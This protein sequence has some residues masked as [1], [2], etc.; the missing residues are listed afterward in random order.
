MH[1]F[2]YVIVGG[3]SAGCVL[4]A[5]LS[6]D[7]D[8][9]V[10]LLEAGGAGRSWLVR[11][12]FGMVLTVPTPFINWGFKTVP[13][14][15]LN[16]R[17]LYQ[18]RGRVLGGSSTLNA[19]IYTRGHP[20]D[21]DAWAAAG[22][23]SWSWAEVLPYF[24]RAENNSR[25][26]DAYHGGEGP[27]PVSDSFSGN[28]MHG[29]FLDAARQAGFV[30]MPDFN[31]VQQEGV[32]VYQVTQRQGER[33]S[34]ARAYLEPN[35]SRSNLTVLT[36]ARAQRVLFD[37]RRA[38]GVQYRCGGRLGNVSARREIILSAGTF[39]SPQLL[40]LSGIGHGEDL[41]NLGIDAL[42]HLPCVGA[43]LQDHLDYTLIHRAHSL[44]LIGASPRG[45]LRFMREFGRY[46]RERRGM[47]CTNVAEAGGFLKTDAA[48]PRPDVQLHFCVAIVH[49]HGRSVQHLWHGY[50]LHVCVLRP[51]SRGQVSLA[52][53]DPATAPLIDPAYLSDGR[54]LE[55]LV[56][57]FKLARR[58]LAAPAFAPYHRREL[59][60]AGTLNDADIRTLIRARAETIYHP[61]G[62]CRMGADEDAVVD[63][64]LKVRGVQGLRVVDASVM[65]TLIGGNTNAPTMMIA[66]KAAEMIRDQSRAGTPA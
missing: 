27:Q 61:V 33:W 53:A 66:E 29:V 24:K 54:D 13:Q 43:N 51:Q 28:P 46:R 44:D 4:A 64:M 55:V 35:L 32:G 15:E 16:G 60:S 57:G 6:E 30:V 9:S 48:L 65:P 56:R 23:P 59:F 42:Q 36:G 17:R 5:R 3:G 38:N 45:M 63:A 31:G 8:V 21:Y 1:I 49:N 14:R 26:H 40:M 47:L 2:D 10:C 7:P 12:P 34:A 18:P 41:Q 39:Q 50:S 19:M 11:V 22:N 25:F 62:T 37:G 58:I 52:S 20:S